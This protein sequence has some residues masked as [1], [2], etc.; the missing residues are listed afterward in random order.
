MAFSEKNTTRAYSPV[1]EDQS[2]DSARESDELLHGGYP[3][4]RPQKTSRKRQAL[5]VTAGV[6]FLLVYSIIL[7]TATSMWWKKER[8]HGA[9]VIDSQLPVHLSL[10]HDNDHDIVAPIRKYVEYEPTYFKMT[11]TSKDYGLV[12]QPSEELDRKWSNIMQ[13][14]Y[15]EIP[16]EYMEKLG[17]TQEGI[18][19][20]NGNYLANYAFIHQ[21]HCLV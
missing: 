14:F 3:T 1:Q 17:R 15:A 8:I 4:L 10:S 5:I 19:L 21:L 2:S 20:P 18:R 6:V 16:K 11:E 12:G 9:N 13:Y 7:T